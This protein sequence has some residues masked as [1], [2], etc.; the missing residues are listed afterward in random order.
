MPLEPSNLTLQLN[1]LAQQDLSTEEANAEFALII[2]NYI[3]TA[4]V[5]GSGQGT[6]GGGPIATTVT[7]TLQ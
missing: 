6:N 2:S 1:N 5:I 4:Q 7:G 3:K